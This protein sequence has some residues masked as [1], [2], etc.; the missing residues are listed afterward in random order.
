MKKPV[1]VAT[2]LAVLSGCVLVGQEAAEKGK[3]AL[4]GK[5]KSELLAC[6]GIPGA[7]YQ[8]GGTEYLAYAGTGNYRRPGTTTYLGNGVFMHAG[9]GNN[10]SCIVTLALRNNRVAAV[11]Y[12]SSGGALIA[13]DEACG[14]VVKSCL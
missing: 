14:L 4:I 1:I 6:A 3:T 13:P 2:L 7:T 11:N 10:T 9:G 5:T 8:D 12:R